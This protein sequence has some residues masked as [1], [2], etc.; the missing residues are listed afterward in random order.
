MSTRTPLG[1]ARK[2]HKATPNNRAT[3]EAYC[4][5]YAAADFPKHQTGRCLVPWCK[6]RVKKLFCHAHNKGDH[7]AWL[8]KQWEVDPSILSRFNWYYHLDVEYET[9]YSCYSYGCDNEGICRCGTIENPRVESYD[10]ETIVETAIAA[11]NEYH[12]DIQAYCI[13]RTMKRAFHALGGFS[14]DIVVGGGYYGQEIDIVEFDGIDSI[15]LALNDLLKH[16]TD[17]DRIL[18][19]LKQEYGYVLPALETVKSWEIQ[20]L[21]LSLKIK[22]PKQDYLNKLDLNTVKQYSKELALPRGIL[23]QESGGYRLIDGHHRFQGAKDAGLSSAKFLVG[24]V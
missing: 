16:S 21:D 5:E 24:L 8:G 20:E 23:I 14:F 11:V 22:S 2:A 3:Q 19:I 17:H 18:H 13:E 9:S 7:P 12:H 10:R 4:R 15:V 6:R 1:K